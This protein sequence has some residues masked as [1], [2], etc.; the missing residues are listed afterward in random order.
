MK[1]G[2]L[3]DLRHFFNPIGQQSNELEFNH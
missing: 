3:L 1:Q 2:W